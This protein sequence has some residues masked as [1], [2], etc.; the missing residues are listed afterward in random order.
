MSI[1]YGAICPHSPEYDPN[2]DLDYDRKIDIKDLAGVAY[3]YGKIDMKDIAT[4]A[5]HF[6]ETDP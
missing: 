2:A 1:L 6:G 4:V 5:R 3:H